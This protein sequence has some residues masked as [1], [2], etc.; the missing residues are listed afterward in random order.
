VLVLDPQPAAAQAGSGWDAPAGGEG[1]TD[2][3]VDA[4]MAEL[5]ARV[6]ALMAAVGG[7]AVSMTG[8]GTVPALLR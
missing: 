6:Q 1:A 3:A 8:V 7:P 4:A 5:H 2:A